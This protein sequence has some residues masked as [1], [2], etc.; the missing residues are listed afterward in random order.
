MLPPLGLLLHL[1]S[2][3]F[4]NGLVLGNLVTEAKTLKLLNGAALGGATA[5]HPFWR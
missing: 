5:R 2:G 4:T 3:T 1:I